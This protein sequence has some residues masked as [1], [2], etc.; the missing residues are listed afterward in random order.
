MVYLNDS[1]TARR[2]KIYKHA[3]DL[4]KMKKIHAT[5]TSRGNILVKPK[6][7]DRPMQINGEV[8]LEKFLK[9]TIKKALANPPVAE[10]ANS[11]ENP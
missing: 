5:W 10:H 1:L 8:D 7:D 3:R 6:P 11:V 4:V 2:A 9:L